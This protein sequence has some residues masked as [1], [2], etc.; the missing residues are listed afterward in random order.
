VLEKQG[1]STSLVR[2]IAIMSIGSSKDIIIL[3]IKIIITLLLPIIIMRTRTIV[4]AI[5]YRI[6]IVTGFLCLN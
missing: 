2:A 5:S 4:V 3:Y 1:F 6:H